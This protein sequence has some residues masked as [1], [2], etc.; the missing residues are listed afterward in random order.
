MSDRFSYLILGAG[1]Q[2]LAAAYDGAKVSGFKVQSL[3]CD[4]REV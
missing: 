2:G 1:K 4:S 3:W